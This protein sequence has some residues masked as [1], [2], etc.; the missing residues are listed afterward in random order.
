VFLLFFLIHFGN[1]WIAPRTFMFRKSNNLA[2]A[3]GNVTA[4]EIQKY[5]MN[6]G[7]PTNCEWRK[8]CSKITNMATKW[9]YFM[10]CLAKHISTDRNC[11]YWHVHIPASVSSRENI[12]EKKKRYR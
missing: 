11:G 10:W 3:A 2:T 4:Y 1:L 12:V 8:L 7:P 6:V 5:I 9:N